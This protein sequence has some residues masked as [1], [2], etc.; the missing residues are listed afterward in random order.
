MIS[1]PMRCAQAMMQMRCQMRCF[2][3]LLLGV[4][5]TGPPSAIFA[6]GK[7]PTQLTLNTARL[8]LFRW[9]EHR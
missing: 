1:A 3:I 7:A 4:F 8:L 6:Q 2:S 5:V 9:R